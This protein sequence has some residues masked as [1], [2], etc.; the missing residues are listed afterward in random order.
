MEIEMEQPIV[1]QEIQDMIDGKTPSAPPPT[2]GSQRI[3]DEDKKGEAAD[4]SA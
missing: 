4:G 1:S 2:T 3:L